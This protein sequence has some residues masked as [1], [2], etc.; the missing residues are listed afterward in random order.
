MV[1]AVGL[2]VGNVEDMAENS[3]NRRAHRVQDPKRL[4]DSVSHDQN[5]VPHARMFSTFISST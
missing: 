3:T 2:T 1:A 5:R 4:V